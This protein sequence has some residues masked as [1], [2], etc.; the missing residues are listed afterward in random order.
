[1]FDGR[2]PSPRTDSRTDSVVPLLPVKIVEAGDPCVRALRYYLVIVVL[3]VRLGIPQGAIDVYQLPE[4]VKTP[5]HLIPL[6]GFP[7][8][9][10]LIT[11]IREARRL[12]TPVISRPRH[13]SPEGL[14]DTGLI[15]EAQW[16]S[17]HVYRS[18]GTPTVSC[19]RTSALFELSLLVFRGGLKPPTFAPGGTTA[20]PTELPEHWY[21]G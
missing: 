6:K 10:A 5:N 15:A 21:T 11:K 7:L 19:G 8:R 18:I 9:G 17:P 3:I 14:R 13:P 2:R 20:L 16:L 4:S 12:S 1:M